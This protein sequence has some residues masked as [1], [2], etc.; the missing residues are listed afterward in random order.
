MKDVTVVAKTIK[1]NLKA[2]GITAKT[3]SRRGFMLDALYVTVTDELVKT[4]YELT[5]EYETD[6]LAITVQA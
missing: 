5:R 4:V 1:A 3:K 2:L 6:E